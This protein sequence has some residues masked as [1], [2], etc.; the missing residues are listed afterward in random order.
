MEGWE[1]LGREFN[2]KSANISSACIDVF[3]ESWILNL[4]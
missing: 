2:K 1:Q 4:T 3:Q